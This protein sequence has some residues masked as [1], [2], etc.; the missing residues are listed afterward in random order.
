MEKGSEIVIDRSGGD[1]VL[2]ED[3]DRVTL[4]ERA[5][6]LDKALERWEG[7]ILHDDAALVVLGDVVAVEA[8]NVAVLGQEAK[9]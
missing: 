3:K 6:A 1:G 9:Q 7:Q 5:A 2:Y 4:V 8:G